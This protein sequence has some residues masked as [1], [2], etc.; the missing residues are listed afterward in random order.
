MS[1]KTVETGDVAY[2]ERPELLYDWTR[3]EIENIYRMAVPE[4]VF[5]AQTVH[6]QFH[7]P[8]RVQTCQLISIKTGG[9][10]E[11]CAYCPQ[12]AHYEANVERQGLLDPEHVVSVAREAADRGVTR[13]C[14][15]AAWR[16]APEGKEFEKVLE[17]VRGVSALGMEVCCTLGMLKEE[18]AQR[19][20]EAGLSAYNHNLDTSPEFYGSIIT[21]RVYEE[22]LATLAAVR[23]VGITVCCGGILGM[24]ESEAD[25][26]GL[27]QQ[28]AALRP[29]PESVP[30]NMLVRVAGTP[31]ANVPALDPMEMVRAI[32]TA[33]I[34]MPASRVRL[35][36]GRK[37]LSEEAVALCF[38][39]GANSIFVGEKLLTTPNPGRDEDEQLLEKLGMQPLESHA[40]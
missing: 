16:Q 4:L 36:A 15:G 22:R 17:M 1:T 14:M 19:L 8:D 2:A 33:R 21:T 40:G 30:I 18:Q 37:E 28:L 5:R 34:L 10:P 27:L 24:G 29:H 23:R 3:S 11:D 31:L 26:I 13:F 12:S 32:A 20:K 9:C 25:R 7:A 6:R 35:A 39:A 38:L